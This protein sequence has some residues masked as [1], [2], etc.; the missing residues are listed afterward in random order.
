MCEN[1]RKRLSLGEIAAASAISNQTDT[2]SLLQLLKFDNDLEFI[3]Q[4][5]QSGVPETVVNDIQ[6]RGGVPEL[7]KTILARAEVD[8]QFSRDASMI[9]QSQVIK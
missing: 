7:R 2:N 4:L 6:I 8:T 5:R 1:V 9:V 3:R